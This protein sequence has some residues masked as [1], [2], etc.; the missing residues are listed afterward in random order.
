MVG[1]SGLVLVAQ[2]RYRGPCRLTFGRGGGTRRRAVRCEGCLSFM[3]G[4][5]WILPRRVRG[6]CRVY[7]SLQNPSCPIEHR[8]TT[9]PS[10][11]SHPPLE[12]H[13]PAQPPLPMARPHHPSSSPSS[14]TRL[15]ARPPHRRAHP[16]QHPQRLHDPSPLSAC[17]PRNSLPSSS[18]KTS[19]PS[20]Q[21]W[22][23]GSRS[24]S[25]S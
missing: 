3:M 22:H 14:R 7:H 1:D 8:Q 16:L 24:G 11:Y 15:S 23:T 21:A 25:M 5:L 20:H 18:Q 2:L 17:P 9:P 6:Q 4:W 13:R 12:Q 10:S 19:R